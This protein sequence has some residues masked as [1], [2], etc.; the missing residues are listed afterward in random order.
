MAV[1]VQ[2]S[3]PA[4][5]RTT[6]G[7]SSAGGKSLN[8]SL[9]RGAVSFGSPAVAAAMPSPAADMSAAT[10]AFNTTDGSGHPA[11]TRAADAVAAMAIE[12][13]DAA[14]RAQAAEQELALLRVRAQEQGEHVAALTAAL[15][16]ARWHAAEEHA[17]SSAALHAAVDAL[18][19]ARAVVADYEA[20]LAA[21]GSAGQE[22][23]THLQA[24]HAASAGA[25]AASTAAPSHVL[26][27]MASALQAVLRGD[28]D[29]TEHME[30][31]MAPAIAALLPEN[32]Y[33]AAYGVG[34][35][36]G[37]AAAAPALASTVQV[38]H[39]A[40]PRTVSARRGGRSASRFAVF[41][42]TFSTPSAFATPASGA[43]DC[44]D[45]AFG[46]DADFVPGSERSAGC[47][48]V[49]SDRTAALAAVAAA[50][51]GLMP[52]DDEDAEA[53]HG[54]GG[55][56]AAVGAKTNTQSSAAVPL[57]AARTGPASTRRAVKFARD[58]SGSKLN[59]S[60]S[61]RNVSASKLRTPMWRS[62]ASKPFDSAASSGRFSSVASG[63]GASCMTDASGA[64]AG[65]A[66]CMTFSS[67]GAGSSA[68]M[69]AGS[70]FAS[71][72][73]AVFRMTGTGASPAPV[74]FADVLA[75][76]MA[77][78]QRTAARSARF[79]R[80]AG[81]APV[82]TPEQL[83]SA[84]ASTSA[85]ARVSAD[86]GFDAV[87]YAGSPTSALAE[88]ALAALQAALQMPS[89]TESELSAD[90]HEQAE[91]EA[92]VDDD[93]DVDVEMESAALEG[94]D[95]SEVA[96]SGA[97][98][99]ARTGA[100]SSASSV[101]RV[102]RSLGALLATPPPTAAAIVESACAYAA[103]AL[104]ATAH[105]PRTFSSS[106]I[107]S[108]RGLGLGAS[109][110]LS[111][112]EVLRASPA[113][114]AVTDAAISFPAG[115]DQ[116][117]L[118]TDVQELLAQLQSGMD[119]LRAVIAAQLQQLPHA[120]QTQ[121]GAA[122]ARHSRSAARARSS[123]NS[124]G[125]V[126]TPSS[127]AAAVA[128][129]PLLQAAQGHW[130]VAC[131]ALTSLR[132]RLGELS[133]DLGLALA[134]TAD[135]T[136]AVDTLRTAVASA[137][138]EALT[139]Q[140]AASSLLLQVRALTHAL[141]AA[142]A[143][144]DAAAAAQK[145]TL[146]ASLKLETVSAA[147]SPVQ[148]PVVASAATSPAQVPAVAF[149]SAATSPLATSGTSS[150]SSSNFNSEFGVAAW[151]C[152]NI[153]EAAV[154]VSP[155]AA[156]SPAA[157]F[158]TYES[159]SSA[160][161]LATLQRAREVSLAHF[162]HAWSRA[163]DILAAFALPA[164]PSTGSGAG[165]RVHIASG[166][167]AG[168]RISEEGEAGGVSTD[169]SS[170]ASSVTDIS[171]ASAASGEVDAGGDT[172]P[173]NGGSEADSLPSPRLPATAYDLGVYYDDDAAAVHQG[174][175][176]AHALPSPPPSAAAG[177]A[178]AAAPPM[179]LTPTPA[180][181]DTSGSP[182]VLPSSLPATAPSS[183][184]VDPRVVEA[185]AAAEAASGSG[186]VRARS[187]TATAGLIF[188]LS[189]DEE[190]P[191]GDDAD[192]ELGRSPAAGAPQ[193]LAL[194]DDADGIASREAAHESD[195]P[196]DPLSRLSPSPGADGDNSFDGS[197]SQSVD[198]IAALEEGAE[199]P[200]RMELGLHAASSGEADE[201]LHSLE[202]EAE[203]TAELVP[204]AAVNVNEIA[205]VEAIEVQQLDDVAEFHITAMAA[206][207]S[208]AEGT[209]HSPHDASL[210][211][212]VTMTLAERLE[213][214][215]SNSGGEQQLTNAAA[216][217]AELAPVAGVATS[218]LLPIA[219]LV[220][221]AGR[222]VSSASSVMAT[223]GRGGAAASALPRAAAAGKASDRARHPANARG[224][225]GLSRTQQ[226]G[227]RPAAAAGVPMATARYGPRRGAA[228]APPPAP[229]GSGSGSSIAADVIHR[230]YGYGV[231]LPS[232]ASTVSGSGSGA[233][234]AAAVVGAAS[235][236]AAALSGSAGARTRSLSN[237]ARHYNIR[238]AV[239]QPGAK[240]AKPADA[241]SA[242]AAAGTS[243]PRAST[244]AAGAA[245]AG[246]PRPAAAPATV[247]AAVTA[248]VPGAR[249]RTGS[250][251]ASAAPAAPAVA[252]AVLPAAGQGQG[253]GQGDVIL[254]I[255]RFGV[256]TATGSS[257]SSHGAGLASGAMPMSIAPRAGG[258]AARVR[259]RQT[260]G[261]FSDDDDHDEA[262]AAAAAATAEL[263]GSTE[264][265]E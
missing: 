240:A 225:A 179:Q 94:G 248:A 149:T 245:H 155:A 236:G 62:S 47:S 201:S 207:A 165:A 200:W 5:L 204:E 230:R 113:A 21:S 234:A 262:I 237:N 16:S 23:L 51:M 34:A 98:P 129:A 142:Q 176:A 203:L 128:S 3:S 13:A 151:A 138:G 102:V 28:D 196:V 247:G 235:A 80:L 10:E 198:S 216:V 11:N 208:V 92:G 105:R 137:Q 189:P 74:A 83:A 222:G 153:D 209:Q 42:P 81:T 145:S 121:T 89:P 180:N 174:T 258:R 32:A 205:A 220:T 254:R 228:A 95:G 213:A 82:L 210:A 119:G 193:R 31:E 24:K 159:S 140:A 169:S 17:R 63:G 108:Y 19:L 38:P 96:Y 53:K 182:A 85:G 206:R 139:Q 161:A 101:M 122:A 124:G 215:L 4:N 109:P 79:A 77:S 187:E 178:V 194:G 246:R 69:T 112:A 166:R 111:P 61:S 18:S 30:T 35:S 190:Q 43:G 184:N 168:G 40:A 88:E 148:M 212:P 134:T 199:E 70:T 157:A 114:A 59:S 14:A 218:A 86:V 195:A 72:A 68:S 71:P 55:E 58:S 133:G 255:P 232:L 253:Q 118:P 120:L 185:G 37:S 214:A 41:S 146:H 12:L 90:A 265:L 136:R 73:G 150:S 249:G 231:H 87:V 239:V 78:V 91:A 93:D 144:A 49:V 15:D 162:S 131:A 242:A 29:A 260:D 76:T 116:L 167:N 251:G 56:M 243:K 97:G 147:V 252:A 106:S 263:A 256:A 36:K 20:A 39:S 64:S 7:G 259:H 66:S 223:A 141:A 244:A 8:K 1:P 67:A 241:V 123:S 132:S 229:A 45:D 186:D 6:Q 65:G 57:S 226:I 170:Q 227:S 257:D 192:G 125:G 177:S 261:I 52:T 175:P 224:A 50:G 188:C 115:V 173:A 126:S 197:Q 103:T 130:Q 233:A 143:D 250:G 9:R 127:A 171:A 158:S 26:Q 27:H 154:A 181:A 48:S 202:P 110:R 60:S 33:A 211:E 183:G 100:N 156:A 217:P 117:G 2:R 152:A 75:R 191:H 54:D 264:F 221:P 107:G 46:G 164:A 219:A 163:N 84:S 135:R 160:A 22:A 238:P 99:S 172:E 104:P 44:H 25:F